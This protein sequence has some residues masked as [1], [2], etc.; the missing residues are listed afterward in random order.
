MGR[1]RFKTM[2]FAADVCTG[3]DWDAVVVGPPGSA[4]S[5]QNHWFCKLFWHSG[6]Q[7][8][9]KSLKNDSNFPSEWKPWNR[10]KTS[11]PRKPCCG[12]SADNISELGD[13]HDAIIKTVREQ[14]PCCGCSVGNISHFECA[15][16]FQ[17]WLCACHWPYPVGM[18][19]VLWLERGQHFW[20]GG[21]PG[22]T[23]S[24]ENIIIGLLVIIIIFNQHLN[25]E[26]ST[27][28]W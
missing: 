24:S 19:T 15:P 4:K 28:I 20:F 6:P 21:L 14:K 3:N 18:K 27:N 9:T 8:T 11:G 25:H 12:C 16:C 5:L 10:W 23:P 1:W 17:C 26:I 13:H 2:R 22:A 7:Q